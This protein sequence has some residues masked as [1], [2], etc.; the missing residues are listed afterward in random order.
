MI[1]VIA[2]ELMAKEKSSSFFPD[3][4]VRRYD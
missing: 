4:R 2:S 3:G 1:D